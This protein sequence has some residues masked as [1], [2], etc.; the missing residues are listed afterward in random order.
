MAQAG[1]PR[2]LTQFT[3]AGGVRKVLV[4][5][6]AALPV[7][8]KKV[9]IGDGNYMVSNV[10]SDGAGVSHFTV[11]TSEEPL[12][13]TLAGGEWYNFNVAGGPP[14]SYRVDAPHSSAAAPKRTMG[15]SRKEAI[16]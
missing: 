6:E 16:E 11:E 15:F 7:K 8:G 14:A 4:S 9:L 3:D 1:N 2:I 13:L 5:L 12:N 10:T